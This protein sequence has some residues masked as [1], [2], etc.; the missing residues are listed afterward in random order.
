MIDAVSEL[1]GGKGRFLFT[2]TATLHRYRSD[3]LSLPWLNGRG[4]HVQ[5]V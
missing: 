3:L 1:G 4:E 5:L 2:D